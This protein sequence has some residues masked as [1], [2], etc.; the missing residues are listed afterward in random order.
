MIPAMTLAAEFAKSHGRRVNEVMS[1]EVITATEDT[2]LARIA[3]ILER[4][5]IKRV[6]IVRGK[7]L[8][9]IVS[10]SNLIQALASATLAPVV[11]FDSDRKMSKEL[12]S[13]LRSQARM[14]SFSLAR[15]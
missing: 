11:A 15:I 12:L 10:R 9:G 4:H 6:P 13:D 7:R 1:R 2:P 8:V 5:R 3:S 14:F